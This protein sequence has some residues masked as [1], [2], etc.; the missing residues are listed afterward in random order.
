M[1]ERTQALLYWAGV[2]FG[3]LALTALIGWYDTQL[4]FGF[5]RP[6]SPAEAELRSG[7]VA[8]AERYL[9]ASEVDGSHRAIIDLYNSQEILPQ[10]YTVSYTD[11]WCATFVS[12]V[13]MEYGITDILPTECGCQRQIA[14]LDQMGRWEERDTYVPL[15][16]DLIFFDWDEVRPGDGQGWAD[17]VGI[18]VGSRWPFLR[19]IEGNRGDSV[20]YHTVFMGSPEIR[21]FGLPDYAGKAGA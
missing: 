15:P 4:P 18:V 14:L 12:A 8:A 17:H 5:A 13:A 3:A 9:G 16:G 11:S 20:A 7:Y 10:G 21:G 19:V 6:V 1:K 2:V